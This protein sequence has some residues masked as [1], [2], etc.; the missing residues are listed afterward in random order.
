MHRGF[1]SV[2]E[3][4][5]VM[6]RAASRSSKRGE[7]ARSSGLCGESSGDAAVRGS[8]DCL[9][10]S[11]SIWRATGGLLTRRDANCTISSCS[12]HLHLLCS[13]SPL[14]YLMT[15]FS[16]PRV[17]EEMKQIRSH[18]NE[19]FGQRPGSGWRTFFPPTLNS[20]S[21]KLKLA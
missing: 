20:M 4:T 10:S 5:A 19:T 9:L 16:T 3:P 1:G 2:S 18:E 12:S 7:T 8:A 14:S 11:G 15:H 21:S 17:G 6:M 13:I